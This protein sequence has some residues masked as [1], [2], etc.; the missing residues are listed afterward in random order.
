MAD[1]MTIVR[2]AL[3]FPELG[4]NAYVEESLKLRLFRRLPPS[5]Y[6]AHKVKTLLAQAEANAGRYFGMMTC[7]GYGKN[8]DGW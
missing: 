8:V 2:S 3:N 7:G 4:Q 5:F 6:P 1:S